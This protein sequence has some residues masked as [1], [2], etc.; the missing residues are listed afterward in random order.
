M[1]AHGDAVLESRVPPGPWAIA[2]W[3]DALRLAQRI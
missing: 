3:L 2:S 1:V